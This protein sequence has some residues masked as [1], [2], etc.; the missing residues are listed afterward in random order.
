[1]L[2]TIIII[3][4][5]FIYILRYNEGLTTYVKYKD[6]RKNFTHK[7]SG[8]TDCI[9]TQISPQI[10]KVYNIDYT[11][12]FDRYNH[13]NINSDYNKSYYNK[14][15]TIDVD[16]SITKQKDNQVI[17]YFKTFTYC[18]LI[19]NKPTC[20]Y[21]TCGIPEETHNK[22]VAKI[23]YTDKIKN[24]NIA[25]QLFSNEINNNLTNYNNNNTIIHNYLSSIKNI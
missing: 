14:N 23:I 18:E 25:Q 2:L 16:I 4:V 11:S 7:I 6:I 17:P 19:D 15:N 20:N 3:I 8:D 22:E 10:D 5:I 21:I 1:M 13:N 9:Y 12:P 24:R